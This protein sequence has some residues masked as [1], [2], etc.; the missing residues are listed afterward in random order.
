VQIATGGYK[1][2]EHISSINLHIP[3]ATED[4]LQHLDPGITNFGEVIG[5]Y[6][7]DLR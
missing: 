1:P 5:S 6:Q 4:A 2:Q 3:E 7:S